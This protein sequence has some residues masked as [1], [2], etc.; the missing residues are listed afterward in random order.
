MNDVICIFAKYPKPGT[1]KKD[2]GKIIGEMAAAQLSRS[3]I[4]DTIAT[5]LRISDVNLALAVW[6]PDSIDDFQEILNYYQNH[7]LD[8]KMVE[9]SQKIQFLPQIGNDLG[10]RIANVSGELI[11]NGADRL[12]II[13][14]DSPQLEQ[15]IF[16]AAF[17]LLN[18][19]DVILGPT[20]DGG[21]YL[22]G[23]KK[24][25]PEL[26]TNISWGEPVIYR[27]TIENINKLNLSWQ[28]LE[29]SYDVDNTDDLEQLYFDIDNH[30]LAGDDIICA[31]TEKCLRDLTE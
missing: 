8:F 26:F 15:S 16:R 27:E 5:A 9:K 2:L 25:Y 24:H 14:Y 7:E 10:E 1:V 28:E 11:N 31:H 29:L 12:L 4:I 13:G 30:R 23:M 20:F 18:T 21:Y 19:N 3:F 17:E 6:P 22:I